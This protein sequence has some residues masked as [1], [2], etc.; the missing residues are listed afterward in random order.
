M[1]Q[2]LVLVDSFYDDPDKVREVALGMEYPIRGRFP[3]CNTLNYDIE[4]S[5]RRVVQALRVR[6][7]VNPRWRDITFFRLTRGSDEGEAEDRKS[8]V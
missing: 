4:D 1:E 3:G 6:V 5:L 8:V 2:T 7:Q